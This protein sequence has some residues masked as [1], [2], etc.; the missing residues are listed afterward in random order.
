[1]NGLV[2]AAYDV[3]MNVWTGHANVQ[4]KGLVRNATYVE[5]RSRKYEDR[6]KTKYRPTT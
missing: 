4:R 3:V 1:M 5:H 2:M 6:Y